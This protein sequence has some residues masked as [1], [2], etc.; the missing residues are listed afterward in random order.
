MNVWNLIVYVNQVYPVL[1]G[2]GGGCIVLFCL[3]MQHI[4]IHQAFVMLLTFSPVMPMN[5][6]IVVLDLSIIGS[7]CASVEKF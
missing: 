7:M 1:S 6:G 5:P 2:G 3:F 4:I